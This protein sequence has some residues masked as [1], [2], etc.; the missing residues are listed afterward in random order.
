MAV[1]VAFD[2]YQEVINEA[3][4]KFELTADDARRV[5]MNYYEFRQQ[6]SQQGLEYDPRNLNYHGDIDFVVPQN[7][8]SMRGIFWPTRND[9]ELQ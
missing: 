3:F 8:C 9:N 7:W 4:E 6:L 5:R 1:V 2:V